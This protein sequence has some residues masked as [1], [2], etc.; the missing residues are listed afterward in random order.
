MKDIICSILAGIGTGL[1]YLWGGLDVAM[2]CLLI[3]IALD[4]VSGIIKAF[5]LKELSSTVGFRGILKKVGILVVVALAVLIDRVTGESGAIRTLVI[6]YFVANEGL[7]ILENAG[8][9]GLPIPHSIKE[10]LQALKRQGDKDGMATGQK[11]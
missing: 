6:Y 11:L 1:V 4:Y 8:K 7:S 9:A 5:V 2:Q 3:A 10:A